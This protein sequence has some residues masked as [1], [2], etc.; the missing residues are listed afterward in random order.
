M[1]HLLEIFDSLRLAMFSGKGGVGKTTLACAFAR[2]WA[3]QFPEEQVLLLSTDPAHSLG[4]I[5]Q[6]PV[7]GE[8]VPLA[9]LPNLQVQALDAK[10]LLQDFKTRYGSVL[11]LLVERGSFVEGG[12]LAPVWEL[13]WPGLDELMGILEIQRLLNDHLVDRVVI[14]MAPS[15]HTLSLLGLREFLDNFLKALTLFQ[16]KHRVISQTFSKNYQ[17]DE[18]DKFLIEMKAELESG[19]Q[20]LEDPNF[21]GCLVVANP[22]PMSWLETERFVA[23]LEK[24][25]ISCA[26]LFLNRILTDDSDGDRLSE[27]SE[28]VEKFTHLN[29]DLRLVPQFSHEPLGGIALDAALQSVFT[30]M[31]KAPKK[32]T[33]QWPERYAPGFRDFI[34]E[35]RRLILVGGKGGV[36]KTTAAA[37]IAYQMSQRHPESKILVISIDPAHSLGDAFG[38]T[39]GHDPVHLAPNLEAQ[40]IDAHSVLEDFR[41]DYLWEL[42]DMMAGDDPNSTMSIAY[43][44]EAWRMI[45]TQALPGIDEMLSL[46]TVIEYL[47][48]EEV[49]LVILDTAPTGHLL[50]FLEMPAALGDWLAWIFKLWMKYQHVLGR[51]EFMGRLRTLR[52]RVMQAQKRLKDPSHTE[53]IGVFQAQAAIMAETERLEQAMAEKGVSQR[54]L[55]WNRYKPGQQASFP[56]QTLIRLGP[57]PRTISALARVAGAADLLFEP[58]IAPSLSPE[59]DRFSTPSR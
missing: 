46:L 18:A 5:L 50:R 33:V 58:S 31:P 53:F 51:T 4:D 11:E 38:C 24:L 8:A 7:H 32:L 55:V 48:Q 54:Y 27:Q 28:L 29:K 40:E 34:D 30:E 45:V 15:G 13:A 12:D 9:D 10:A 2:H 56:N 20:L 41:R 42:A 35:K 19:W 57:L 44:P 3:K 43:G 1:A 6:V 59:R 14:D 26:G 36:G 47:E 49:D 52:Q 21:T 16:E 23:A 17:A 22:E 37:A 25:H 39:L